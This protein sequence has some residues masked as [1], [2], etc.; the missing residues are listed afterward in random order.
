MKN[1]SNFLKYHAHTH[2]QLVAII[3][4]LE[5]GWT[6]DREEN[7]KLRAFY[8]EIA[9]LTLNH[10]VI[11]DHACV[12]AR[13]LGEV[14]EKVDS[15]WSCHAGQTFPVDHNKAMESNDDN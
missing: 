13:K 4:G 12:T 10:D 15:E 14:L 5:A 6:E 2:E 9:Q 7:Q 11:D 8:N 3:D 1:P